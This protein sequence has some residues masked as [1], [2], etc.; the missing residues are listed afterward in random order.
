MALHLEQMSKY[1][2][3]NPL[4]EQG[5]YTTKNLSYITPTLLIM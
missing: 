4:L 3:W 2:H 5:R 1:E